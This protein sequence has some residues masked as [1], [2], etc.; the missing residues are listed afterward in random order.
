LFAK[1]LAGEKLST[2]QLM[3]IQKAGML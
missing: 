3:I 1:F 2:E